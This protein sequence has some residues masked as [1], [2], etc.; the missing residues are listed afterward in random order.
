[1]VDTLKD[2]LYN[3]LQLSKL[4]NVLMNKSSS[5]F[6]TQDLAQFLALTQHLFTLMIK[7]VSQIIQNVCCSSIREMLCA[8][9]KL[10]NSLTQKFSCALPGILAHIIPKAEIM[11]HQAKTKAQYDQMQ[12]MR[13][14]KKFGL[15]LDRFQVTLLSWQ[16]PCITYRLWLFIFNPVFTCYILLGVTAVVSHNQHTDAS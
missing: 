4:F 6:S 14:I 10:C 1:M 5:E 15:E 11:G 9:C 13:E 12:T 8:I 16:Q 7:H 3:L 2:H